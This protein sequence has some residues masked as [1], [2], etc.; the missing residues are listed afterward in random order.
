MSDSTLIILAL[1]VPVIGALLIAMSDRKPNQRDGITLLTAVALFAAVAALLP[2]VL[3]GMRPELSLIEVVPG[4]TIAFR[5]EPLGMM[6]AAVASFLWIVNSIYS[7]G[8]MRG[9]G[10]SHQTRF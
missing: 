3:A 4:I 8:Y 2:S 10:E 5:I 1:L 9:N 6:F 7:I